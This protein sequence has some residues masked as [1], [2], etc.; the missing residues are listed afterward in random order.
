MPYITSNI[1]PAFRFEDLARYAFDNCPKYG[2]PW[3]YAAQ[4][5]YINFVPNIE[6]KGQRILS[7]ILNKL[8]Y[9]NRNNRTCEELK[10]VEN[11]IWSANSQSDA[12][13]IISKTIDLLQD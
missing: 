10:K 11:L 7:T 6:Q 1:D 9:D 5:V 13:A 3:G 8:I 12:I 2:D 4:E